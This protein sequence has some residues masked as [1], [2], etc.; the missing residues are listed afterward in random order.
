[1][2]QGGDGKWRTM[3]DDGLFAGKMA[4]GA[5][6]RAE[7]GEGL[8]ELGCGIEKTH[9][10]G[11][12]EIAGVSREV[13]EAFSTRRAEIEAAMEERGLGGT[14]KNRHLAARAALMTRAKKR[15]VDKGELQQSWERQAAELGFSAEAARAKAR[16]AERP[17]PG[18]S[19]GAAY[20]AAEAAS[21]AV[22]HVSERAAVF[23]HADLL[24]AVLAREPG[25]VTV[26][27]AERAIAA[28]ER[29]GGLH[30]ARCLKH[31][32]HWTTD[33]AIARE[34]EAIALMRAGQGRNGT[35][36][37]AGSRRRSSTGAVSTR[38]RRKR[39]RWF[40]RRRIGSWAFRDTPGRARRRC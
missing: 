34:S 10:D 8:R 22:A 2:V 40:F 28:L 32:R 23:G 27:A 33:A 26:D 19:E 17:A 24:A 21:W 18:L 38:D 16:K 20:T 14:G 6:Y 9:A 15:D 1:M 29:E 37:G 31:D 35:S 3:V 13:V 36:C 7:L 5:I 25:A 12:F 39:S 30:G 4:I 11:R